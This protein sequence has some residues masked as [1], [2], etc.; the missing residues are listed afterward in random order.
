MPTP[1]SSTAGRDRMCTSSG[2][3]PQPF[4]VV[5]FQPYFDEK[6]SLPVVL[7]G[8][9]RVYGGAEL[10]CG[11]ARRMVQLVWVLALFKNLRWRNFSSHA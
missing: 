6:N 11:G 3:V 2:I 8:P 9:L 4:A 10:L 7:K 1:L 5:C